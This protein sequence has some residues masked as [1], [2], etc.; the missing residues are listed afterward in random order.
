MPAVVEPLT[1]PG[2]REEDGTQTRRKDLC[3]VP[4][5]TPS[6]TSYFGPATWGRVDE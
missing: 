2:H 3:E 1:P 5:L 6:I 4:S